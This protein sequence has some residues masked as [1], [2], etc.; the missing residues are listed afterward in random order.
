MGN[1]AI[2]TPERF[3]LYIH[4]AAKRLSLHAS[5]VSNVSVYKES[6]TIGP[7][8]KSLCTLHAYRLKSN[9]CVKL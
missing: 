1:A 3:S 4:P 6:V 8:F 2:C 9:S 5:P 7:A